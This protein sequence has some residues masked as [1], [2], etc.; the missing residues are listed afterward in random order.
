[1]RGYLSSGSGGLGAGVTGVMLFARS[2]RQ[3][4]TF[5]T[6]HD[7]RGTEAKQKEG[8]A[9]T[10]QGGLRGGTQRNRACRVV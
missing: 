3:I 10:I 6:V 1:M 9:C 5:N 7:I 8:G 4:N 2:A